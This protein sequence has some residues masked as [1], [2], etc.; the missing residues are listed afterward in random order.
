MI[1]LNDEILNDYIDNE[2]DS[3]ALQE[4][5]ASLKTDEESL[6]K[7]KALKIVDHSLHHLEIYS[8]PE[9]FTKKVM[10]MIFATSKVVAPKVSYFFVTMVSVLSVAII[11]FTTAAYLTVKK[12]TE[13][14]NKTSILD[15]VLLFIKEKTPALLKFFT[16]ENILTIGTVLTV[17]L[18]ISGYFLLESHKNFRNKLN[19]IPS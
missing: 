9:G 4:V 5:N 10:K 2:L 14:I 18:L 15:N 1:K 3:A 17:V 7:L 12:S 8:A 16:N 13:E 19:K 11:S 6:I